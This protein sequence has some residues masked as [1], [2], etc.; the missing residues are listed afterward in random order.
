MAEHPDVEGYPE[1]EHQHERLCNFFSD[2]LRRSRVRLYQMAIFASMGWIGWL[3]LGLSN[4]PHRTYATCPQPSLP[5]LALQQVLSD[6]SQIFGI[7]PPPPSKMT[8]GATWM[9][10]YPDSTQLTHLTIPGAHDA[11]TW[12]FSASTRDSLPP[13][14]G[15]RDPAYF[16]TQRASI[17][18]SLEAGLRFFDLRYA[19]DPTGT[20]LVFWHHDA[21]L[22]EVARVSDV[23][24]GFYAWLEAHKTETLLLSFQYEG[25]TAP[26]AENS[27][28]VQRQ[29]FDVLTSPGARRYILQTRDELGALGPARGKIALLRRFDLDGLPPA[30]EASL[31]GIHLSPTLWPVNSPGFELVYNPSRRLAAYIEDYYETNDLPVGL[32]AS[33][34]IA[35]KFEAVAAHLRM[36]AG[37]EGKEDS[38]FI[39]FASGEH[40]DNVPPVFPEIMAVGNGTEYTPD[41]GVNQQLIPV[42][43][44]LKGQRLGV[45]VLDYWDEPGELV[46]A[47]L[48]L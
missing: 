18:S 45:V 13:D 22:S 30:Y 31:P 48:G 5:D 35:K 15:T 36:A 32:N 44:D 10:H 28:L 33:V 25:G 29:L 34:N 39:T 12:N 40:S 21:L 16:R 24:F 17:A 19:L 42:L 11:A 37:E 47:I 41:G 14:A 3:L 27:A 1:P 20:T 46:D 6:A 7:S 26:G 4:A 2:G 9:S 8:T 43:R 38:L 23:M